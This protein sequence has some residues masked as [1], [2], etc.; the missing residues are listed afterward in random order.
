MYPINE[1]S[2]H[3]YQ[4]IRNFHQEKQ[5]LNVDETIYKKILEILRREKVSDILEFFSKTNKQNFYESLINKQEKLKDIKKQIKKIT[6]VLKNI[7]DHK[8]SKDDYSS[9]T[10]EN[11]RSDLIKSVKNN[12]GIIEFIKIGSFPFKFRYKIYQ[13]WIRLAQL[14]NQSFENI[15]IENTSL[16]S[17]NFVRCN[18]SGSEFDNVDISGVNLNGAELFNCKWKNL[19]IHELNKLDDHSGWILSVCLSSDGNILASGS[20]DKSIRIWDVKK[21]KQKVKLDGNSDTIWSVCFSPDGNTLASGS[22]DKSIRLWDVKNGKEILPAYKTYKD[23]LAQFQTPLFQ[24][25]PLLLSNSITVLR[26]SQIPLFQAQGDFVN[27]GGQNFRQLFKSKG[28]C[29]LEDFKQM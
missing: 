10:Q 18:L 2:Q 15:R 21:G 12:K 13:M 28:S 22:G 8:L 4:K 7:Q 9:E 5:R 16:I 20:G 1:Q 25:N 11:Q 27:Y 26:I 14:I 17:G 24:N 3:Y 6:N 19:K 23:I 29:F